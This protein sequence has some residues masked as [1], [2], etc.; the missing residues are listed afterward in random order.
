MS[1]LVPAAAATRHALSRVMAADSVTPWRMGTGAGYSFDTSGTIHDPNGATISARSMSATVTMMSLSKS[2]PADSLRMRRIKWS[3]RMKTQSVEKFASLWLRVDDTNGMLVLDNGVAR[4]LKGTQEWTPFEA[5][6]VVPSRASRIVFGVLLSGTGSVDVEG[7]RI[8]TDGV[9]DPGAPLADSPR[10][11]LNA[12]IDVVQR[13]SV[14]RD[15]VSWKQLLPEVRE[16]AA[17]AQRDDEV[18]AAIAYLVR[19]M[20]DNHSSFIPP[21]ASSAMRAAGAANPLPDVKIVETDV[22]YVRMEGYSGIERTALARYANAVHSRLLAVRPAARCGWIIDLR[23]NTGGNMNPMLAALR[24]FLGES[25][26]GY[27]VYATSRQPWSAVTASD[28]HGIPRPTQQL[29]DLGEAPVAVLTGPRTASSGEIIA[30]SFRGRARTRS[31]GQPTGGFSTANR[32]FPLPGGSMVN[33]TTA[34][35]A[36]RKGVK[37][38]HAVPPDE[39]VPAHEPSQPDATRNAA[40]AWVRREAKCESPS[41]LE[42]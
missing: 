14:W 13:N 16:L 24:P 12:A 30:I 19:R 20:G 23:A 2:I 8:T 4:G 34:I 26:L 25:T 6:A 39:V 35:D 5:T 7:L 38:G 27:F 28:V 22:G 33:L 42:F 32:M 17:G 36:D 3:G 40:M 37:F 10:K 29:D 15:T 1:S 11:L 18:Y 9:I 31:F 41:A 21:V